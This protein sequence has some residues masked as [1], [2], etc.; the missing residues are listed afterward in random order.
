M[1]YFQNE[2]INILFIHIPKTGGTSVEI[3]L[4]QKYNI[5]L[6]KS[7]LFTTVDSLIPNTISFQHLTYCD[8]I[9]NFSSMINFTDLQ[10]LS[11]VRNPYERFISDLFFFHI[12]NDNTTSE[13]TYFIA[14]DYLENYSNSTRDNHIRP[15]FE[16][17]LDENNNILTNI[18]LFKT[19]N[20]TNMMKEINLFNDFNIK[21]LKN[22]S[23]R[24]YYS[25]LNRDTMN[26]INDFYHQDFVYFG[27][28]KL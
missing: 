14:K 13:E 2:L 23:T 7:S 4:S 12:I 17:L 11:I 21:A 1:P 16:F 6:D 28:T 5:P 15:Q 19:E 25:F 3:Y 24:D 26:L 22:K 10:I 27:Y 18:I 8:I 20:L 9:K